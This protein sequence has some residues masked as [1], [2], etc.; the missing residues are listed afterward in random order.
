M[1][2]LGMNAVHERS[3]DVITI[4]ILDVFVTHEAG[5]AR[6]DAGPLLQDDCHPVDRRGASQTQGGADEEYQTPT[7]QHDPDSQPLGVRMSG[8]PTPV[9]DALDYLRIT[10]TAGGWW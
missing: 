3:D 8:Y 9:P 1:N 6:G 7:D 2:L 5:I 10:A 4:A